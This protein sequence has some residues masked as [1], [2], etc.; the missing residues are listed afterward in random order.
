MIGAIVIFML[1]AAPH[2]QGGSPR[3]V[4]DLVSRTCSRLTDP[5]IEASINESERL[6]VEKIAEDR[7]R[8]ESLDAE[9]NAGGGR[10]LSDDQINERAR[11][12]TTIE[13]D[14][15]DRQEMY[16]RYKKICRRAEKVC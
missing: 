15:S 1:A 2:G 10:R 13:Q 11:V 6:L 9:I 7:R 8:V 16:D 12:R 4:L 5:K 3:N 14:L